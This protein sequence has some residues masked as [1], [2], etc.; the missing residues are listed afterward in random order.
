MEVVIVSNGVQFCL[1]KGKVED[2]ELLIKY[3]LSTIYAFAEDLVEEEKKQI[4][5]YVNKNVFKLLN[6]YQVILIEDRVVGCLLVRNYEDGKL[7][8][9]IYIEEKYRNK[10]IG[11][12]LIQNVISRQSVVYLWV[13]QK[14]VKA[15]ALYEKLGFK[16]INETD[17]RYF[18]KY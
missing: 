10:G 3:K 6:D 8:D 4:N 11:T 7:L 1:R 13:Y 15:I 18:M 17:T 9:E 12:L 16:K 5:A 14:N 2:I